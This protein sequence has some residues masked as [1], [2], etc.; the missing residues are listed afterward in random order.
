LFGGEGAAL[1]AKDDELECVLCFCVFVSVS[2]AFEITRARVLKKK[3]DGGERVDGGGE[4]KVVKFD[5]F[6]F[7]YRSTNPTTPLSCAPSIY[8]T[9]LWIERNGGK[10][11]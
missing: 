11:W 5:H 8:V 2:V 10:G 6:F 1:R 9:A 7:F 3:N 4:L